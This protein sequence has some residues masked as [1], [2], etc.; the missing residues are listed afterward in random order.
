LSAKISQYF[1]GQ[2]NVTDCSKRFEVPFCSVQAARLRQP[3]TQGKLLV[4]P[5]YYRCELQ[6]QVKVSGGADGLSPFTGFS[7]S[8]T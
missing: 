6:E 7:F 2:L 4:F 8:A 5:S 1:T 3:T